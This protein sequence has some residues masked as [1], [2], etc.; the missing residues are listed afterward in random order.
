VESPL[1]PGLRAGV[2]IDDPLSDNLSLQ[3]GAFYSARGGNIK[4]SSSFDNNGSAVTQT[5]DGYVRVD[6]IELPFALLYNIHNANDSRLFFGGGPYVAVAFGGLVGFDREY[7]HS[8]GRTN[9]RVLLPATIGIDPETA[10]FRPFDAGIQVQAGYE[11]L[12]G[13]YTRVHASYGF[14]DINPTE[15][16]MKNAG[17]GLTVGYMIR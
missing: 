8:G 14:A 11:I 10:D 6:Y 13:I 9:T 3:T 2:V 15:N 12:K 4:Y 1:R 16:T 17:F 7:T 5:T